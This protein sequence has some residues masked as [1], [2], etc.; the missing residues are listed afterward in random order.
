MNIFHLNTALA[1]VT[2]IS[3][4]IPLLSALLTRAHWAPEITGLVTLALSTALAFFTTWQQSSNATHYDW[5]TVLGTALYSF[6]VAVATH[7]GVW[8]SGKAEA[9]LKAFP[10][11]KAAPA[12]TS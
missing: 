4:V 11:A 3:F 12:A 1:L 10:A 7:Y 2:I 8:K 5:K 9:A 6:L